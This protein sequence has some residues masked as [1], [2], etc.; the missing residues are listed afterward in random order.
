MRFSATISPPPPLPCTHVKNGFLRCVFART[1]FVPKHYGIS[2]LR[3]W[4][5]T[6][7]LI[8]YVCFS[9]AI[10]TTSARW[11]GLTRIT[12]KIVYSQKMQEEAYVMIVFGCWR[13]GWGWGTNNNNHLCLHRND[14]N[15][16]GKLTAVAMAC[17]AAMLSLD[18]HGKNKQKQ[19]QKI[20]QI[21]VNIFQVVHCHTEIL[22]KYHEITTKGK[23]M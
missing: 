8:E 6:S 12:T 5:I 11:L 13:G 1:F 19:E 7:K 17:V 18:T 9:P 16:M 10:A 4:L 20:S 21:I 15:K 2:E 23:D 14:I 22:I 3:A